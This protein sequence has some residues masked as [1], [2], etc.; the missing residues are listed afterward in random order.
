MKVLLIR[1]PAHHAVEAEVPA[2]VRQ[3]NVSYPPLSLVAIHTFLVRHTGHQVEVLDGLLDNMSYPAL[4]RAIEA[5]APDV[6][7]ISAYTLGLVDVVKT[8]S[9]ARSA[10]VPH[11]LLGGP[12]VNDFPLEAAALPGV[13]AAV[14][15]EGQA[16]LPPVL[17]ALARGESLEG[18]PGVAVAGVTRPED[19]VQAPR[20][21][22]VLDDYPILDLSAIDHARYYDLLGGG[23]L[24]TTIVTSRGCP[25]RCT[26]CNTPRDR[27]RSMSAAR[28]CDEIEDKLKLGIREIYFVDDTFNITNERVWELSEEILRRG[29]TFRW[30]AR[31]RANGIRR[32][33]L[34]LMKR[35][36]CVRL[37]VGV[38][39]STDEAL[40][41]LQKDVTVAEVQEA[42]RLCREVGIRTVA[43]FMIGTPAERT[44]ADVM[45]TIDFSIELD[46]DF[47]MY[48]ILTP[49]PRTTLFEQG[50][51]RGVLS[52]EPWQRFIEAPSS[53]FVPPV[54]DEYF[55]AGELAEMLEIAYRRFYFRPKVLIRN[56]M[57]LASW[58]EFTKKAR[59]AV[60][61]ISG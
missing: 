9:A 25:Y 58:A 23:G 42:F 54:W 19:T 45:Q 51:A 37:Q 14:R 55:E 52:E 3:E 47:V 48:N 33:L 1:P 20:L 29:L 57:S 40:A 38:E 32:D 15:G 44:R 22:D 50:V 28:I 39:Q 35:A 56:M 31:F 26:F 24:F 60:R 53:E 8:V 5:H 12:H 34:R 7:G 41:L 6:V 36:G 16:T 13:D 10:G 43:Y 21:S 18:L 11:V 49:F 30:T 59:A 46:P 17:D 4:Q 61:L 2:A 27:F